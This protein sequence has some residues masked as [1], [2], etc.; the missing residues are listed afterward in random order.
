MNILQWLKNKSGKL[1]VTLAQAAGITAVVGAAGLGALTFLSSPADNNNTFLPPTA[2]QGQVVYVS[3]NGGG[4][5]YEAN[6][7]VGSSFKAAPSRSIQLANRAADIQAQTRALDESAQQAPSFGSTDA[8][9]G[10]PTP[11]AY[12]L[13]GADLGQGLGGGKNKDLNASLDTFSTIQNQLKGVTE[14]MNN[15]QAQAGAAQAQAGKPGAPAAANGQNAAQLA[16]APRNWGSGGLTRAGGGN[17][18]A[19]SF[20][21]QDS[22]KNAR[23]RG[24]TPGEMAQAGDAIA[25]AQAAMA[26]L[27]QE[28]TRLPS[29]SN[30]GRSEGF[31]EDK[32]A[33][34]SGARRFGNAKAELEFIRKKSA[35]IASNK[36]NA[37]NEGGSPFLASA[38][39]SGGLTVDGEQVTT[40]QTSTSS[41]F[42][43][44]FNNAM[45]GVK[46][47][48][49]QVQANMD[50]RELAR[51]ELKS[52]LWMMMTI[53]LGAIAAI[54]YLS[55]I[56]IWGHAAALGVAAV[57]AGYIWYQTINKV[58]RY[59]GVCGS[60]KWTVMGWVLAGVTTV[61]LGAAVW[62]GKRAAEKAVKKAADEAMKKQ[63]GASLEEMRNSI[64]SSDILPK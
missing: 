12:Q 55:K 7:E 60:D 31:G 13:T 51:N 37:A 52:W 6:G 22:G 39:I 23:T 10:A 17:G 36:T 28:G 19:N 38:K 47:K 5:Q 61:G 54:A 29:R 11:Q 4:G 18:G 25:Q 48:M 46:A 50:E 26:Q 20:A 35:A 63:V 57:T 41:D 44:K 27:Q 24:A 9:A 34:M 3:Q 56:P 43:G 15:A 42:D 1:P 53:A 59:N 21:I 62:L 45:K 49:D 30:F 8:P 64:K 58:T 16:S 14:A 32:N 33:R 40:G 2:S